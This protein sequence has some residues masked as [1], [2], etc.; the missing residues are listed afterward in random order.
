VI[1]FY[2]AKPLLIS[3]VRTA[4]QMSDILPL[5]PKENAE[6]MLEAITCGRPVH[7]N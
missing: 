3:E 2:A 5:L 6:A 7:D 4:R 1:H